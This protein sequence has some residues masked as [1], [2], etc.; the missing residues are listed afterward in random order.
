MKIYYELNGDLH[1]TIRLVDVR[2]VSAVTDGLTDLLNLADD[3][4]FQFNVFDAVLK[5]NV[6]KEQQDHEVPPVNSYGVVL[7]KIGIK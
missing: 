1:S 6:F 4:K 5:G 3:T 2:T 7:V